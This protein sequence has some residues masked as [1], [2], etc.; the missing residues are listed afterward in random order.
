MLYVILE[1]AVPVKGFIK[2]KKIDVTKWGKNW[3]VDPKIKSREGSKPIDKLIEQT[4]RAGD[5]FA[6]VKTRSLRF[7][8]KKGKSKGYVEESGP[9]DQEGGEAEAEASDAG[10]GE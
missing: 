5:K 7:T 1:K 8:D 6:K 2:S 3:P 4:I 10:G 9:E